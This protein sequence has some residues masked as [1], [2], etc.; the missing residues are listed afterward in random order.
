MVQQ[1]NL[2]LF[3]GGG[4]V[5]A[6]RVATTVPSAPPVASSTLSNAAEPL[7]K[8]VATSTGVVVG[9]ESRDA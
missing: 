6:F 2:Q 4:G 3:G 7:G 1:L 8:T 5:P 9:G